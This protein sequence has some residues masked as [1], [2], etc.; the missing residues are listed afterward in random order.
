MT[1]VIELRTCMK[2]VST[3][4]LLELTDTN[5]SFCCSSL[6]HPVIC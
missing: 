1:S 5:D 4:L 2:A 3:C 6:H